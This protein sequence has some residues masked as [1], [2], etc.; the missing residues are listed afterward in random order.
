MKPK[1]LQIIK[2]RDQEL[3]NGQIFKDVIAGIIVAIIALPLS[4]ALAISSGVAP[5]KG[6]ITAIIAGFFISFLGGSRVQIGGPTAAFVVIIF[7]II[8]KHGLDGLIMATI[9]AGI[10]LVIFGI[11][12]FGSL[13]K[14]IPYPITV[15][16]TTGIA[17]TLFTTQVKDFLGLQIDKV[18]SEFLPKW[19]SYFAH[20]NTINY[21]AFLLGAIALII[22][23]VWPKINKMIPG[24]LV[25]LIVITLAAY[26]FKLNVPTI[27]STFGEISSKIPGITVP[28]VDLETVIKLIKPAFTI[29]ILAS[30]ESLLSAVVAD[31]MIGKKHN[32]NMELIGQGVANIA[33]G[34][35]G[36]IPATGAIARTA[37]NVKNG[38]RTPIAGI[39]HAVTLFLIMI[40]FMPLAKYI[41]LTVLAAILMIVSYNMSE[42]KVFKAMLKGP[43]SDVII[44]ITTCLLTVIFDLVVAIEIGMVIAMFLFM[45]R[46]ANNLEVNM[47]DSDEC[48]EFTELNGIDTSNIGKGIVVYEIEGALFFG[49]VDTFMDAIKKIDSESSVLILRM[50][51]VSMLDATGYKVL[52]NIEEKCN[53]DNIKLVMSGVNDQPYKVMKNM[54]MVKRLGKERFNRKFKDAV[55]LSNRLISE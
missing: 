34:L 25:A 29:A 55:I 27:G 11:C 39:T 5:E 19:A 1:L 43:K 13:I 6:L 20:L 38:G 48:A 7:G 49:A 4:I 15:G 26:L 50:R 51:H 41:P 14:Y 37:A 12:K 18:P 24:S 8:Q 46:M 16:F 3:K 28:K 17:I 54:G 45:R 36:G 30:I 53:K 21:M 40:I 32:S 52:K 22:M 33:S 44:L 23:I 2:H 31:G 35:F 10:L 9:M 42:L 47:M